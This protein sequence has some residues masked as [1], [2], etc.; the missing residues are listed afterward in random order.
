MARLLR[1]DGMLLRTESID[2]F[3]VKLSRTEK[4]LYGEFL[5]TEACSS[6]GGAVSTFQI[7]S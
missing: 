4:V 6:S 7:G 2:R 5:K 1:I 3:H